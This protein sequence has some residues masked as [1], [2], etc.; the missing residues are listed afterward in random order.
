MSVY[1]VNT[2][3]ALTKLNFPRYVFGETLGH[4]SFGKVKMANHE[5][6]GHKVA[7]KI[8]NRQK[9]Q[10]LDVAEKI[11]REIQILKMFR[12]PHIIKLYEVITTPTDIFM[13]MEYVS[14]GELFDY[15]GWCGDI[16]Y[17]YICICVCV[18]ICAFVCICACVC[19]CV[20]MCAFVCICVHLCV[21]VCVCVCVCI[22]VYMCAFM[23]MC[24]CVWYV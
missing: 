2:L 22:C 15:I 1:S 24:V 11:R 19:V 12:H 18:C 20:Y 16:V 9:I 8:L 21:S 23:C 14:G 4:G 6:T 5:L 13:I 7:V 17:T 3:K 10:S